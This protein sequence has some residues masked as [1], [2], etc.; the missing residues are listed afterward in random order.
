MMIVGITVLTYLSSGSMVKA[1][2]MAGV[3]LMLS[4]VGMDTIS[5]KYRFTFGISS[6]LDG[7]TLVPVA[8][9]MFGISE[10]LLNLET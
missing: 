9:G 2:I 3:G 5:G 10:V 1:L 4:G 7:I 8:M 6:L